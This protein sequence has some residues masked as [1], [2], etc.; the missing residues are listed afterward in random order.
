MR[1]RADMLAVLRELDQKDL[2]P[3]HCRRHN[4]QLQCCRPDRAGKSY[5]ADSCARLCM[6]TLVMLLA[7]KFIAWL[8]EVG[9]LLSLHKYASITK[10]QAILCVN[11]AEGP[12]S[13]R[14]SILQGSAGMH[15]NF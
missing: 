14:S 13:G 11:L 1:K 2:S 15:C 3:P 12:S 5:K 6:Q 8:V 10:S 4:L 7:L 9:G